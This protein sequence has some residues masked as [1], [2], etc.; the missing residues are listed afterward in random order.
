MKKIK[1]LWRMLNR[2]IY[3]GGR[4]KANLRALTIVSFIT[5]IMGLSMVVLDLVRQDYDV[6]IGASV[7]FIGG[8]VCWY[9]SGILKNRKLAVIIPTLFCVI[10][11][12]IYLFRGTGE[13]YAVL[14]SFLLPIGLCY[15]VSVRS[16]II[17][18]LYY[19]I[20][21]CVVFYTPLLEVTGVTYPDS[22]R[23]RYP[24]TF[25]CLSIFTFIAM[26]Q[27]HR[28]ALFEIEHTNKLNEEVAKQTAVAEE[29]ARKIEEMSYQTI[30]TLAQAIDAKDPYTKGHSTRVS[31]YS[32]KLAEALGWEKDR[33]DELRF[34]ALLHDLG[35]IG[36]PDSILNNPRRLTD[37]EY[38]IIKSHTTMGGDI[39]KDRM[40][41]DMA[42]DVARSH[43]ERYDG[44]GYPRGLKGTEISEEARIVAI[45][46]SFDAMNSSRVYRKAC[47]P[48]HI[49]KELIEGRG[50]QF[51]PDFVNVFI[52]LWDHG[53]LSEI[54][55]NA[56]EEEE[57]SMEASSAL[58]QEVMETFVSQSGTEE[59]DIT[60]GIMNRT[61]G[62]TAIAEAMKAEK[63]CFVFFDV[64]NLKKINDVSGH[65]AGDRV[66]KLMGETLTKYNE[67]SLCCR[68]GGDEFLLFM[69][70][71]T[72]EEAEDRVK[73]IIDEFVQKK[74]EDV[75]ISPA[76]LSAGMVM[77]K[78]SYSYTKTFNRA[79]KAL[80]HVKQNGKNGYCFYDKD[81]EAAGN[82]QADVN[83]L[84]DGIR[85]SGSYEGAMDVEYR[86]FAKLFEFISNLER[87]FAHPFKLIMITM[88]Y[89]SE[90]EPPVEELENAMY[91]ME[92]SI[93]QT[94]RDVDIMTRYNRQ[95]FL[96]ILLGTDPEGVKKAA[97]RIFRGYY[98]MKGNSEFSP[99]YSVA[100][101]NGNE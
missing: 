11:F 80:Y 93:L 53:E 87:R 86:E 82:E 63:G 58:L 28:S 6:L 78:T 50:T 97:D 4:L 57:E 10:A 75:E 41:I 47:D 13:G 71:V 8:L 26:I 46:D 20:L 25:V 100:D 101:M 16:G 94:I 59:M 21:F 27:Y 62:E 3:T 9:F 76:S 31:Q 81:A 38:D 34:A 90:E 15:F 60:T 65:E 29:R 55:K 51:D 79:D 36:V 72:K 45:A 89:G 83:Q 37:V 49:S 74:D 69:K 67:N 32:V 95:Q 30:H 2:P 88:E 54:M 70:N 7:T 64:D 24:L 85:N 17:L 22:F 84:V 56:P 14:Y 91:F 73:R 5:A 42:E 12:T 39:L 43:H 77:S 1:D 66:L 18:S 68:I 52:K 44:T 35:K 33:I 40:M 99:S 98:K 19:C 48:L 96:V 61:S 23:L 92:Q